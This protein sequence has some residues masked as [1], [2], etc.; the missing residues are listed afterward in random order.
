MQVFLEV[1]LV[2]TD[3]AS[4]GADRATGYDM[5]C[6]FIDTPAVVLVEALLPCLSRY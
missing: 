6:I 1:M 4:Q 3:Q 2:I 5:Q